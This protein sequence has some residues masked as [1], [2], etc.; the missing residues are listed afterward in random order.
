MP[1][2]KKN[3]KKS[4]KAAI[5][6]KVFKTVIFT[7]YLGVFVISLTSLLWGDK[8]FVLDLFS[9][10]QLQFSIGFLICALIILLLKNLKLGLAMLFYPALLFT[11][12]ILPINQKSLSSENK[13]ADLYYMNMNLRDGNNEE[14]FNYIKSNSP[15]TVAIVELHPELHKML[16][17]YYGGTAVYNP[18]DFDSCGVYTK[19]KVFASDVDATGEYPICL[20]R[21]ESYTLIVVHPF[22]AFTKADWEKQQ[23]FFNQLDKRVTELKKANKKYIL[24]GDFNASIYSPTFRKHFNEDFQFNTYTWNTDSLLMLPIDHAISNM[25]LEVLKGKAVSSD[26][27]GLFI[28]AANL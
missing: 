19:E 10:F 16:N 21:F 3:L 18:G 12:I 8:H 26:H 24:V 7:G 5:S 22:P 27:L 2:V 20:V 25:P 13:S 14:I 23:T 17:E 6:N 15:S 4:K 28:Y 9:H 1:S 11:T